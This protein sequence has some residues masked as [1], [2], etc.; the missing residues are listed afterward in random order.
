MKIISRDAARKRGLTHFYTGK[1][2]AQGHTVERQVCD[3]SCVT[4]RPIAQRRYSVSPKGR[5][6]RKRNRPHENALAR[7]TY[8]EMTAS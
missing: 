2:C 6:T 7:K 8:A 5:A 4:C 3:R 1:P